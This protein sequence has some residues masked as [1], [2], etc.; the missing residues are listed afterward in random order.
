[1][2]QQPRVVLKDGGEGVMMVG[3]ENRSSRFLKARTILQHNL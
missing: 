1:M 3:R 2:L